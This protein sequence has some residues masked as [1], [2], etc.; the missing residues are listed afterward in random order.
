MNCFLCH[1]KNKNKGYYAHHCSTCGLYLEEVNKEKVIEV[2]DAMLCRLSRKIKYCTRCEDGH[3]AFHYR[4]I[5]KIVDCI[6]Y[7]EDVTFKELE[8]LIQ[9]ISYLCKEFDYNVTSLCVCIYSFI[10][11]YYGESLD[12]LNY[13][14]KRGFREKSRTAYECQLGI[15]YASNIDKSKSGLRKINKIKSILRSLPNYED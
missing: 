13:W 6:F 3:I 9:I 5:K 2:V 1:K 4:G 8:A 12:I 7:N 11:N 14:L 10:S 15:L